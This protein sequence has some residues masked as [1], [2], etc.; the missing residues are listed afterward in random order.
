MDDG[1]RARVQLV[2]AL[3]LIRAVTRGEGGVGM[4]RKLHALNIARVSVQYTRVNLQSMSLH[5]SWGMGFSTP[6]FGSNK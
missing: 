5:T 2:C 1:Y 6:Y 3:L 4:K